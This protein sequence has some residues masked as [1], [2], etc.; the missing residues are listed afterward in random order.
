[1]G[2]DMGNGLTAADVA[3]VTGNTQTL[4]NGI[5][6]QIKTQ[7]QGTQTIIDK[8]CQLELD[9]LKQKI[10]D[11]AAEIVALRGAA[12]RSKVPPADEMTIVRGRAMPSL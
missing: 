8:L 4:L 12:G 2:F 1:M 11:Q 9:S 3:A 5:N 7:Q 10:S 6:E